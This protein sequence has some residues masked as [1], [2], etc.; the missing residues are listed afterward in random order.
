MFT[1]LRDINIHTS[2]IKVIVVS[3]D[4]LQSVVSLQYFVYIQ[5]QQTK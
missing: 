3:P 5:A 1:Q 2:S 4:I